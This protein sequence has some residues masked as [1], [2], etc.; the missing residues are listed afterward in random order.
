[1]GC[2]FYFI[3]GFCGISALTS[4]PNLTMF[5]VLL[6]ASIASALVG[7]LLDRE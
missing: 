4:L 5:G 1:M 6:G 7:K 2:L 3:A